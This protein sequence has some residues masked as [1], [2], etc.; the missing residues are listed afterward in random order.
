MTVDM[1]V[2]ELLVIGDSDL[3]IHQVQGE[4]STK[5]VKILPYLHSVKELCKK[6]MMIEFKHV[7]R[8]QNE[9]VDSLETL[10]SMIQ[11]PDKN[12]IDPIEVEIRDKHAYCFQKCHQCQI[13]RNFI[14]VLP[15]E[16][17]VMGSPWPFVAWGMDVIGPIEPSASNGNYL[18]LVAIDYFTKW[19]EVSTYKAVAKKV[20]ENFVRNNIVCRFVILKSIITDNAAK[21][22]K[23]LM[24]EIYEK[25][26]IVHRNSTSYRPQMNGA[27]EAEYQENS[28]K[29]SGQSH[30]MARETIL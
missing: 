8:I 3:L 12:Y 2:K 23:D 28:V 26:R 15:N 14:W 25:F 13:H 24:R 21:L 7:P 20:V 16:L 22:N 6:F 27:V 18:I 29:D 1:N 30:A 11:Y 9:F 10:S 4:W 17:N 5:Y 19:V